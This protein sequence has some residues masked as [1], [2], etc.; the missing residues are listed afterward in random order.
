MPWNTVGHS[1]VS[2][3]HI[4]RMA[5]RISDRLA[6]RSPTAVRS[7]YRCYQGRLRVYTQTGAAA[8]HFRR[9]HG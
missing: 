3:P 8:A 2:G 9:E 7:L 5:S 6:L 1:V 4:Y